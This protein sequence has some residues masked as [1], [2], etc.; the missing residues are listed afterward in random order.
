VNKRLLR[1]LAAT[2][3]VARDAGSVAA[4][5]FPWALGVRAA[6]TLLIAATAIG[7]GDGK[8]ARHPVKGKVTVGGK[9]AT[10][11]RVVFT[12]V[13]GA[14]PELMAVRPFGVTDDQ[15]CFELTT[16]ERGD[17]APVG[18]YMV[19][20]RGREPAIPGERLRADAAAKAQKQSIVPDQFGFPDKSGLTASIKA[21]LNE[22]P[23]FDLP[24]PA[25]GRR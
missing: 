15:G 1:R 3:P 11:V 4:R 23:P 16:F 18:E 8:I 7:C 12:P 22:L 10:M 17:G 9:P 24:A 5:R 14:P 2:R 6:W 20:V 13:E 21:G 19:A 25:K